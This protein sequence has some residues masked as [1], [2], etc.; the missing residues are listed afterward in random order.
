MGKRPDGAGPV[1]SENLVTDRLTPS[2]K[3]IL[4]YLVEH[5]YGSSDDLIWTVWQNPESLPENDENI[6][7][8]QIS[9]I[10]KQLKPPAKITSH[11]GIGW[12]LTG[13]P[14]IPQ[15][16]EELPVDYP[17]TKLERK[18]L[19][20]L[21]DGRRHKRGYLIDA[22][23]DIEPSSAQTVVS[24]LIH[25]I[26]KKLSDGWKITTESRNGWKLEND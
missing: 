3:N 1:R 20:L 8:V 14:G 10:R 18:L 6:L 12:L 15:Y 9:R 11:S 7:R 16:E 22:L 24:V 21:A 26:R 5:G 23:Y 19:S 2:Q 25:R 13:V 17:L 4:D